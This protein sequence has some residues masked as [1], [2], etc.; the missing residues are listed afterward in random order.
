[1]YSA[2]QVRD[3]NF[4]FLQVDVAY[5]HLEELADPYSGIPEK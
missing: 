4:S 2:F 3:Q 5:G 1:M